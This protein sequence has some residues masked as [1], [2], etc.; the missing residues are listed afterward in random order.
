MCLAC[1]L[2]HWKL[3][4][5]G[6]EKFKLEVTNQKPQEVRRAHPTILNERVMSM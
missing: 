5:H 4:N 1:V 3:R 2:R 6:G